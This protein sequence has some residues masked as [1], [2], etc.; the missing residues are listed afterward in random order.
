MDGLLAMRNLL[1]LAHISHPD[2]ISLRCVKGEYNVIPFGI[3]RKEGITSEQKTLNKW[4]YKNRFN[5][6]MYSL[7]LYLVSK[8][9]D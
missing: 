9:N 5:L 4:F 2:E 8:L 7:Y 3:N 1:E 6:R